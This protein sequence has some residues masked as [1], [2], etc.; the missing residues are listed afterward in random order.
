[1]PKVRH[2]KVLESTRDRA[3]YEARGLLQRYGFTGFSFQH[4]ADLLGIKKPSLYDHFKSKEE[5]GEELVSEYHRSFEDWSETVASFGPEEKIGAFFDIFYK[6]ANNASKL[7][8]L[9]AFLG[10]Y[11]SLPKPIRKSLTELFQMQA[12]W[13]QSVVKDGQKKKI[14]R[15]DI[16]SGD[17]ANMIIS[18]GIG[19][20]FSSRVLEEPQYIQNIKKLALKYLMQG[21]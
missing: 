11:H 21:Q 10:N 18:S 19:S 12:A 6:F 7:C 16:S 2:S 13:V 3:L 1:M 17:L 5:L 4:I 9:S 14:F 8:P 15:S 20:Q